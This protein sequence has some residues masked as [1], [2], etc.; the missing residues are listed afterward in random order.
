M[1]DEKSKYIG[2][3]LFLLDSLLTLIALIVA[4]WTSH[5]LF[6]PEQPQLIH[7]LA[8]YII[9]WAPLG[10]F[11][12]RFGAYTGLRIV[13]LPGFA[14]QVTKA[15]GISAKRSQGFILVFAPQDL[16]LPR[17]A[18]RYA[19]RDFRG[20]DEPRSRLGGL[21]HECPGYRKVLGRIIRRVQLNQCNPHQSGRKDGVKF[22]R[23]LQGIE[24]VTTADMQIADEYLR[25]YGLKVES[26]NTERARK[27]YD[28][29]L[30][31]RARL[32]GQYRF[33]FSIRSTPIGLPAT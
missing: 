25:Q 21:L 24:V 10:Y 26:G 13:S 5:Y 23:P 3:L 2:R 18:G 12:L 16:V 30:A 1:Y 8:I 6:A 29:V 4:Y 15:L 20:Q 19:V 31:E 27:L 32:Y 33:L 22:P 17:P 7:Y 11:L 28:E 14:W 9:L